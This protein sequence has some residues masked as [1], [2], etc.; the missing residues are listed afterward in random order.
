LA[1]SLLEPRGLVPYAA[2]AAV[3]R[4]LGVPQGEPSP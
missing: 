2:A 3:L 4:V 1:T